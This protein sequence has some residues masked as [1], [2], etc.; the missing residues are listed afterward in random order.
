MGWGQKIRNNENYNGKLINIQKWYE[1]KRAKSEWRR[2]GK[3]TEMFITGINKLLGKGKIDE[4]I[5]TTN[6][7]LDSIGYR[8]QKN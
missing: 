2:D 7:K 4:T 1:D 6:R 8:M 3:L 5:K